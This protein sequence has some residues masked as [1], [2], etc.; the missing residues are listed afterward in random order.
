MFDALIGWSLR[1][2]LLVLVASLLVAL[3]GAI[4]A[5]NLTLDVFPEFAP[6]QAEIRVEA[7]GFSAEEVEAQVTIPLEAA[8]NGMPNVK[9]VRS[10]S[11]TG[12]SAITV[13]FEWGSDI[14]LERQLVSERL[15][16]ARERFPLGVKEPVVLP[17]MSSLSRLVMYGLTSEAGGDIQ[18][19]LALRTF[20]EWDVRRRLLALPGVA[21]VVSIGGGVKQYQVL[22]S[23]QKLRDQ[24]I[25]LQQ[26]VEAAKRS[27]INVPGG[28][29][30]ASDQEY[31]VSGQGRIRSLE[32]LR[33]TVIASRKGIPVTL[34]QV[35]ELRLGPEVKRGDASLNVKP[36]VLGVVFKLYGADTLTTTYRVEEAL[37]ELERSLPP[38]VKMH[39]SVFR[40]ANFIETAV[41]N[42]REA[43]LEGGLIVLAVLFFFFLSLRPSIISFLSMPMS[44]FLTL[45]LLRAFD[46][47]I[48]VMTLGGLSIALGEVVDDAII[49]VEN[50]FRRLREN[51]QR[52]N[53]EPTLSVVRRASIEIRTSVVYATAIVVL[54]F[55]PVFFL[56]GPEGKIFAPL[57]LA[58]ILA[59]SSSLLVALTQTP[60]LSS[61]LLSRAEERSGGEGAV[62]ARIKAWYAVILERTLTHPG[63]VVG[64]SAGALAVALALLPFF[65]RAFLPTFNEGNLVIRTD[66]PPGTSL[67]ESMRLGRQVQGTLFKY[68]E[69]VSVGQW[70]GRSELDEDAFP[71]NSSE[72]YV[73]LR[74]GA[75]SPAGLLRAIRQDLREIPGLTSAVSA[76]VGE[77]IDEVL[78][79]VRAQ[80]A[81]KIFGPD[82]GALRERGRQVKRILEGIDGVADLRLE[83]QVAVP[84]LVIRIDRPAAA[85]YG[86]KAEEIARFIEA[87]FSG[88]VASHVLEGQKSFALLVRFDDDSRRSVD[89][90]KNALIDTP[91]GLKIP[92]GQVADVAFE[93]RP[94]LVNRENL[95]RR[96]VVQFNVV[97]RDLSSVLRESRKRIAA[98]VSLP[99]G[100][101]IEYGGQYE[102]QLRS[103][104]TLLWLGLLAFGGV[105]LLL[106]QAFGSAKAALV[107]L[108]NLPLAMIGGVGAALLTGRVLTVSSLVGFIALFG[109]AARN[110]IILVTHYQRLIREEGKTLEEA[111]I[112]GSMDRVSPIIMTA[113]VA[114]LGFL[115]LL[116]GDPT[117]KELQR[118]LA[119]VILGGLV[120]STLLNLVV[121]PTLVRRFG[122]GNLSREEDS[123]VA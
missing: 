90:I 5:R 93:D 69:V 3:A 25:S 95:S 97:G 6:P 78:T 36:A 37:N 72:L 63:W 14:Y 11:S 65:G 64:V 8:L 43:L 80:V 29:L 44:F 4:S 120:T 62:V 45:I 118:P 59:I 56:S 46:I 24:Q 60:V 82:L 10:T 12:L 9:V 105:C 66:A 119:W 32:D 53:P 99:P 38:G 40:Q 35:A 121:V 75:R 18:T 79:G 81:V 84:Q 109:I 50:I 92:L 83:P 41:Q 55:L 31:V 73:M 58:Y 94:Y 47:G 91:G 61:L 87:A 85:R 27:N 17:V 102:S 33:N 30:L 104:Q 15:R 96:I 98:G 28:F 7:P 101:F 77:R 123:R 39:R 89:A 26:V 34:A 71:V 67:A 57:G 117:G 122:L 2:R 19:D 111:V 23:P 1:N 13:V 49:D 20:S 110:G 21:S 48:N 107:V 54:F 22:V 112:Q 116:L 106:V 70:T 100:Y 114:A 86:L 52:P 113:S 42:L 115:P 103:Q 68:P 88:T 76:F 16:L 74:P 108:V 51:R